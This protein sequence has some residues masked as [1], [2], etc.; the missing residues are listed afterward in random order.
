MCF[1][2]F[3]PVLYLTQSVLCPKPLS[4]G[5]ALG[6]SGWWD[7]GVAAFGK[8][9]VYVCPLVVAE[10]VLPRRM[11]PDV[12]CKEHYCLLFTRELWEPTLLR[13]LQYSRTSF[14][15]QVLCGPRVPRAQA[16]LEG[17]EAMAACTLKTVTPDVCRAQGKRCVCFHGGPPLV[18]S[19]GR[20]AEV[21]GRLD[22]Q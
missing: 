18:C 8:L 9:L 5:M 1:A 15:L 10:R 11:L 3:S 16:L 21:T 2:G 13:A 12:H 14:L 17:L 19:E 20:L 4:L 7:G 6:Q 22:H